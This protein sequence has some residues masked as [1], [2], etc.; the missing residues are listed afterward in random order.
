M[1]NVSRAHMTLSDNYL[2]DALSEAQSERGRVDCAVDAAYAALLGV[3][4]STERDVLDHPN[5][6][7]AV[8]AARRLGVDEA[9]VAH[10]VGTR[11]SVDER[12]ELKVVLAWAEGIRTRVRQ[13]EST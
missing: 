1:M 4:T 13:L 3:L 9:Q 6:E 10:M 5:P 11:Y 12:P 7:V 2:Q 8:L